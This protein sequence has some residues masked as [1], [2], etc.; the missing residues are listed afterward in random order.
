MEHIRRQSSDE[1]FGKRM[2]SQI[3][4]AKKDTVIVGMDTEGGNATCQIAVKEESTHVLVY[5]LESKVGSH[6]LERGQYP[7]NLKTILTHSKAIHAGKGVRGDLTSVL[8]KLGVQKELMAKVQYIELLLM[9]DFCFMLLHPERLKN[10]LKSPVITNPLGKT[11]LRVIHSFAVQGEMM[12]K[13]GKYRNHKSD[14]PEKERQIRQPELLYCGMDALAGLKAVEGMAKAAG[15]TPELL[16]QELGDPSNRFVHQASLERI[17]EVYLDDTYDSPELT[18]QE[19]K[20]ARSWKG[21][22]GELEVRLKETFV[23]ELTRRKEKELF[24]AMMKQKYE[25]REFVI[26][27]RDE[28]LEMGFFLTRQQ[29][30][31]IFEKEWERRRLE[32]IKVGFGEKDEEEKRKMMEWEEFC[33][34]EK[35]RIME[36]EKER[37]KNPPPEDEWTEEN[38][39]AMKVRD[40]RRPVMREE[41]AAGPVPRG[42]GRSSRQEKEGGKEKKEE[43]EKEKCKSERAARLV[44]RGESRSHQQQEEEVEE[45]VEKQERRKV[46]WKSEEVKE[47]RKMVEIK[48]RKKWWEAYE[49]WK[50]IREKEEEEKKEKELKR[51][52]EEDLRKE[53]KEKELKRKIEE[54]LRKEKQERESKRRMEEDFR[55]EDQRCCHEHL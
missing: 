33:E 7:T 44:P 10:W 8:T 19:R 32:D 26:G 23:G 2:L 38:P 17:A 42:E 9:F 24:M 41:M 21:K 50:L 51:K 14:Y 15:V 55:E 29:K 13:Q 47:L 6:C 20:E 5:Q 52:I 45:D 22:V 37:K 25:G 16:M 43:Q 28:L 39:Y 27:T 46:I 18:A 11:S 30:Q 54:D 35:L 34:K 4:R 53:K 36:Y 12:D 1:D 49:K 3:D 40:I 48:R 31:R